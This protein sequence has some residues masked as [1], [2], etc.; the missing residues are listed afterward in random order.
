[1]IKIDIHSSELRDWVHDAD[2]FCR[3]TLNTLNKEYAN[4]YVRRDEFPAKGHCPEGCQNVRRRATVGETKDNCIPP[5]IHPIAT[6]V[7]ILAI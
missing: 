5:A 3:L 4:H 2:A 1:M 6:N 7:A